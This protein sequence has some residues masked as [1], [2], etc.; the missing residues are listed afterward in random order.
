MIATYGPVTFVASDTLLRTF[1][2]LQRTRRARYARHEVIGHKPLIEFTGDDIDA[3]NFDMRFDV[4]HG[5][6][7]VAEMERLSLIREN[8]ETWPLVIAGRF[9]SDFVITE[10]GED[11]RRLDGRGRVIVSSVSVQMLEDAGVSRGI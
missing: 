10:I 7:P 3:V 1:S 8:G 11:W 2:N 9:I 5:V 4:F 6:D